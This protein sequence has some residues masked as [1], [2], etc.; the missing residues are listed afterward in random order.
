ML[1]A[2]L[3]VF[4]CSFPAFHTKDDDRLSYR[5]RDNIIDPW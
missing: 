2:Y 4:A 3:N 5:R 1:R